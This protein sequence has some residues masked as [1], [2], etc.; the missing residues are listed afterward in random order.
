MSFVFSSASAVVRVTPKKDEHH[1]CKSL[2][3]YEK[4]KHFSSLTPREGRRRR[5]GD[6]NPSAKISL[7][8]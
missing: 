3:R 2:K 6:N 1:T 7:F 5:N 8:L 4:N